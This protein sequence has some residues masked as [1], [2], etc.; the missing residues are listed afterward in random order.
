M[1]HSVPGV[2]RVKMERFAD[3]AAQTS[4]SPPLKLRLHAVGEGFGVVCLGRTHV[5]LIA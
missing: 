4:A 2:P 1:F 5:N 3:V